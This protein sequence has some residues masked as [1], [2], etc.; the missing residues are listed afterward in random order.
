MTTTNEDIDITDYFLEL[1][2]DKIKL[3]RFH[4]EL[5]GEVLGYILPLLTNTKDFFSITKDNK[6]YSLFIPAN[7]GSK[8]EH[9]SFICLSSDVYCV[10]KLYTE[11]NQINESGVVNKITQLFATH[12][13]PILFINSYSQNF[14]LFPERELQFVCSFLKIF[15]KRLKSD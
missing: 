7:V 12:D 5:F 9:L 13:V 6:E 15:V 10:L 11:D 8:I 14:V 1:L 3:Y 2:D 4:P